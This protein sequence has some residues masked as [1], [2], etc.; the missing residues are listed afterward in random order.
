MLTTILSLVFKL[1]LG[2]LVDRTLAHMERKAA[3]KNDREAIRAKVEIEQIRA[4]TGEVRQMTSF[5]RAKLN[6]PAFWVF[7][8]L[9]VFPVGVWFAAGML[10][11]VFL[12]S[13]NV[14]ALPPQLERIAANVVEWIF[15]VGSGV[16]AAALAKNTLLK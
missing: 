6:H 10:D 8:A 5:N 7:A 3:L 4:A 13:W 9:F 11:S 1:G 2:P 15:Y 16:G 14:A 12:F